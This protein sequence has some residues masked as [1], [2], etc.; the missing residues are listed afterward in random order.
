M[1]KSVVISCD[2]KYFPIN[3][4]N[5]TDQVKK[6]LS[7]LKK[8]QYELSI[9]FTDDKQVRLL[10][11]SYRKINKSTD[12]LSFSQQEGGAFPNSHL[13]GDIVIS[14]DTLRKN[15][16]AYK[17]T[18]KSELDL[19]LIH[20]ILHLLGYDHEKSTKDFDVMKKLE[21]MVFNRI[22]KTSSPTKGSL[23]KRNL[24]GSI[25]HH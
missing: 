8:Q 19:L 15:A 7:I 12:I 23:L 20:G 21:L 11:R 16:K 14:V 4:Y 3:K 18:I 1:K 2:Y 25:V 9:L 10:N 22:N 17:N 6:I 24:G 5:L 13:L